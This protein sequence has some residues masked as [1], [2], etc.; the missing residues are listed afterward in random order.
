M[1]DAVANENLSKYA[2]D[3]ALDAAVALDQMHFGAARRLA[4][5]ALDVGR[6][7]VDERVP[8]DAFSLCIIAQ[9]LYE[10]GRLDEAEALLVAR[11]AEIRHHGTLETALRAHVLLA[12]IAAS[13]RQYGRGLVILGEAE[14][15]AVRHGG[16][17]RL[18][19]A[20]LAYQVELGVASG[21]VDEAACCLPQ[22]AE[23]ADQDSTTPVNV[24]FDI[25]HF[26]TVAQAR[27]ALARAPLTVDVASLRKAHFD[28]ARRRD[29]YAAVSIALL[30]VEA[31]QARGQADEAVRLLSELLRV[32]PV[33][34]LHQT[35]V[36]CSAGVAGLI[37]AIVQRRIAP[38][39]DV[40]ELRSYAKV[41]L[42]RRQ[43]GAYDADESVIVRRSP[44]GA[45]L[46]ERERLIVGLM[47]QGLSNKQIAIELC[48]AP[49]TVKSHAK[50]LYSKL[51]VRNRTEAVTLAS[52]LGLFPMPRSLFA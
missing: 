8:P 51:S 46:S 12:R 17:P 38:A 18:R 16:W 43:G 35:L 9:T 19:A 52:R 26:Y 50:R 7:F 33:V 32:A 20:S 29:L 13:R 23:L 41:L 30:L 1:N 15:L 28:T 34:G 14:A 45:G 6:R 37:E 21:R 27:L 42:S 25:L 2:G 31:L 11:L 44:A 47:G 10:E 48:I 3:L 22:L 39:G 36:D 4:E 49:E 24:K 40:S 5:A